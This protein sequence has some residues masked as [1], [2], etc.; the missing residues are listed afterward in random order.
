MTLQKVLEKW[1]LAILVS[2]IIFDRAIIHST[3]FDTCTSYIVLDSPFA[4]KSTAKRDVSRPVFRV[5]IDLDTING[6]PLENR[7][8]SPRLLDSFWMALGEEESNVVLKQ[9]E[10]CCC[11]KFKVKMHGTL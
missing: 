7:T 6:L 2:Y 9:A 4:F 8:I 10:V 5:R 11:R 3:Y 1:E